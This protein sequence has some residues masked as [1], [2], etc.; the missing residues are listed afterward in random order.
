MNRPSVLVLGGT[1]VMGRFLVQLLSQEHDVV[2][3]TRSQQNNK[4]HVVHRQGNA[5][6]ITFITQ[7]LEESGT[8]FKAIVDFMNYS[9][10]EFKQRYELLLSHTEQLVFISSA[11]VYADS[12]TPIAESDKRLLDVSKDSKFLASDDY[13]LSKARQED[14]LKASGKRNWTIVRPYMTYSSKKLDLGFYSKELWL[15]RIIKGKRI[16]F[17]EDVAK[18]FTTLTYGEDV[19]KGIYSIIG[20]EAAKGEVYHI[21]T[22]ESLTWDEI[23]KEYGKLLE[24]KGYKMNVVWQKKSEFPYENIYRYDRCYDRRFNNSKIK[25]LCDT[26]SFVSIKEGISK[27][28]TEFLEHPRWDKIDWKK[29]AYWDKATKEKTPL[30]EIKTAKEKMEYLCFRYLLSYPFLHKLMH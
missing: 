25:S 8:P 7:V 19:A 18:S 16:L 30:T 15:Y 23:L 1:G 3:T 9:T 11:R 22:D 28:L 12:R 4:P 13:S 29:Q 6:D 14:L 26:S 24:G 2:V 27:S 5:H 17:T 20:N 10:N 21:T